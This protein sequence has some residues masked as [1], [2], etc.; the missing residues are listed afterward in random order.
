MSI[1][2]EKGMILALY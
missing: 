1:M 2:T